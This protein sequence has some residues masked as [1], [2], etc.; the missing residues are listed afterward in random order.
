MT[1]EIEQEIYD[2]IEDFYR[3]MASGE[4]KGLSSREGQEELSY[5]VMSRIGDNDILIQEAGVGTGKTIGYLVPLFGAY[6]ATK[7]HKQVPTGFVISTS[8]IALQEQLK[9]E[10]E[11][12]ERLLNVKV[13]VVIAKG[14][15]NYVCIQRA[16]AFLSSSKKS[17]D[18]D[19]IEGIFDQT[20][21]KTLDKAA[22][23]GISGFS[24]EKINVQNV[25]C[26]NCNFRA[27][28]LYQM[29]RDMW[30]KDSMIVI[31]NHDMLIDSQKKTLEKQELMRR[32][33]KVDDIRGQIHKP[34][35]LV[36]DEAH[37]LEERIISAYTCE[38]NSRDIVNAFNNCQDI[39]VSSTN[40]KLIKK[41]NSIYETISRSVRASI[42]KRKEESVT[43]EGRFPFTVSS[44]LLEK[45]YEF[46]E[47]YDEFDSYARTLSGWSKQEKRAMYNLREYRDALCDLTKA[48]EDRTNVFWATFVPGERNR[49]NLCCVK[50]NLS[51]IAAKLFKEAGY[52]KMFTSATLSSRTFEDGNIDIEF[53]SN[54]LGLTTSEFQGFS[55]SPERSIKSP[56]DYENNTMMYLSTSTLSPR[57]ED[58]EAYLDSIA[59][60]TDRLINMSG[61]RSLILF[62]SKADMEAVYQRLIKTEH[63]FNIIIQNENNSDISKRE[64]ME[65]TNACLLAT[66]FWE[67]I[68]VKGNSLEHVI[69]P[70]LPFPVVDPIIDAKA[71]M[72]GGNLGFTQV[73]LP[74]MLIKLKQGTGRLIRGEDDIGVVS[75]LDS[76]IIPNKYRKPIEEAL[77]FSNVTT[78]INKVGEFFEEKRNSTTCSA[79]TWRLH[80]CWYNDT[81]E[82]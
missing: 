12:L 46:L 18:R 53:F 59:S 28:C 40:S 50:R 14:K 24:W 80:P 4:F 2:F 55:L 41:S 34:S 79:K 64:F 13:P 71:K 29:K 45:I 6:L 15:N 49:V 19:T 48:F 17:K 22:Y 8:T 68:D 70:K 77:P 27:N 31:T 38:F 74:S 51:H 23:D 10:V 60:E 66:G 67:G 78:D 33:V 44:N 16:N 54:A 61:G 57:D 25:D 1:R 73:Y 62:T 65:D 37:T 7:R 76:R 82:T 47:L 52:G 72:Y 30:A 75:I 35:F 63:D 20:N 36:L 9:A 56:Y 3:R 42:S 81:K 21:P 11:N 26:R 32:G 39:G 69:I 58:H 5:N 43:D